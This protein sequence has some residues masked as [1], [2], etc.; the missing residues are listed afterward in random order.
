VAV[1]ILKTENKTKTNYLL[2]EFMKIL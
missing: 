2:S 1:D